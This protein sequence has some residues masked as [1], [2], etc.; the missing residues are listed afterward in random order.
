[1]L[2]LALEW[3]WVAPAGA[4]AGTLGWLGVRR[5]SPVGRRLELDAAQH[6]LR[7]AEHAVVRSRALLKVARA[8]H[9]RAQAEQTASRLAAGAVLESKRRVQDAERAVKAAVA[10]LR[11]R[12]ASV[13]AARATMPASRAPLEEMPLARLRSEHDALTTRWI[14]YETDAAKAIDY[15]GMSDPSSP[16]LQAFLREQQVAMELRPAS[17]DARMAPADF[18]AYR[19]AVR[20]ATQAFDTAERVAHRAAGELPRPS[21]DRTDWSA[22]AQELLDT[23]QGAITRSAEAWQRAER[24][25]R[26]RPEA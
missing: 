21:G 4:G 8:E 18:A 23:A 9:L 7:R 6:D 26:R 19:D 1:M 2:A 11:A 5:R 24:E 12:R 25:R 10:D 14:A 16:A 17:T 3:W 22:L 20:R 13:Q 15:P